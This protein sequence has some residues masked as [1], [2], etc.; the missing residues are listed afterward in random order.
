MIF[1]VVES[2]SLQYI[3]KTACNISNLI[4]WVLLNT[5]IKGFR[6][7]YKGKW[8]HILLLLSFFTDRSNQ[9]N[10]LTRFLQFNWAFRKHLS[11]VLSWPISYGSN[12]AIKPY[13]G[14]MAKWPYGFMAPK[15]D[16]SGY[17]HDSEKCV[18][19]EGQML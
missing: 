11:L 2:S 18:Q 16:Q 19:I 5:F 7:L 10:F 13:F 12:M 8:P 15:K 9:F 4:F 1:F 14:H 3:S 17:I 6:Q